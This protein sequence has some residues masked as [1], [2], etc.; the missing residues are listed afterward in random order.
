MK[1]PAIAD[2]DIEW[3]CATL[4]LPATAFSGAD[5]T[6][7]RLS[8]MRSMDMLD[9]EACPGSGKT[10]L[11]VAKLAILAR[12]WTERRRGLCVLSHTN[13]ARRE[14]ETRLGS[15]VAGQRL[16]GYPHFIGTIHGFVNEFLALPW[17]RSSGYPIEMIDDEVCL[18]HRWRRLPNAIRRGLEANHYSEQILRYKDKAFGFG[19]IR[20]GRGTLGPNTQTYQ[21]MVRVCT[22][23]AQA[24]YFCHDEMFVWAHDMLDTVPNV[25]EYI[26]TRF[27]FLF[28]D[29]VQDNSEPQ[30]RLLYRVFMDGEQ[31]VT[32]QRLGDAN[33]A[34]YQSTGQAEAVELDV[35]PTREVRRDMPNSFRFDQSIADLT[36]PLAVEPQRLTGLRQHDAGGMHTILLFDDST[37]RHVLNCYA[38]LL[39]SVFSDSVLKTGS[40]TAIGAV[41]RP[42][43]NDHVPRSVHHYWTAYDYEISLTEPQPRTLVQYVAAGNRLARQS[44]EAHASIEKLAEGL[45][46]LVKLSRHEL[47]LGKRK[48]R[49]LYVLE[50]LEE[51]DVARERYLDLVKTVCVDRMPLTRAAWENDLRHDILQIAS[52]I[53]G[54]GVDAAA[55]HDFLAWDN[56]PDPVEAGDEQVRSD[57]IYHYSIDNSSVEIRVGSIH[58]AKGETHTATLVLDTFY[59]VH[60]IKSLKEWLTGEK[61]GGRAETQTTKSRLRLHYVAMT[62]PSN[63]LCLAMREDALATA[64]IEQLIERGWSVGRVTDAG[65]EWLA[66]RR[67]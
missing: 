16:L 53:C 63:L 30:S 18:A 26:R 37:V 48:R 60:H 25:V 1:V 42:G 2:S 66:H 19:D 47:K 50:L 17:L 7:P 51:Q 62:R 46:R 44:G 38:Q 28:V 35:F 64:D 31:P 40:F 59:R 58:S 29:E 52:V 3:V 56:M 55:A 54:E 43:G 20:W 49:H 27:P 6:D 61:A 21:T 12:K 65:I 8:I 15:T 13:V 36:D 67:E 39:T 4:G 23:S 32:R 33:Q 41:H 34:I 57:N 10:T 14:I 5:G 9:V 22:A 24:G 11:L 45:L